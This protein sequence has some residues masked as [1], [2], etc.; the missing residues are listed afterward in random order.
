[1][2]A[3]IDYDKLRHRLS[4]VLRRMTVMMVDDMPANLDIYRMILVGLGIPRENIVSAT[5]GLA[6]YARMNSTKPDLVLA[7]WN[8][9]VMDGLAFI[10][11]VHAK[12]RF[13]DTIFVMITA[14]QDADLEQARPHIDAFLRKPA[15]N[16]T[17]EKMILSVVAKRVANPDHPLGK[18][19]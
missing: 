4:L 10:K 3:P 11:E 9:P 15:T 1:M 18:T 17:I 12:G 6:A 19:G 2:S 5:N 7:D 16:A 14:E 13:E 8:M